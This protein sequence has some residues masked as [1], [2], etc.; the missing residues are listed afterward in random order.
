M[1]A[2][3][4][5]T[6]ETDGKLPSGQTLKEAIEIVDDVT[7]Q[8]PAYYMINCAHPTHFED[9]LS[10]GGRWTGRIRGIRAN[11][12]EKSHSQLDESTELDEGNPFELGRQ[13]RKLLGKLKNINVLG[14]CC[15]TDLRHVREIARFCAHPARLP[16]VGK[17]LVTV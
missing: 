14:G 13:Y 7:D 5:F 6:V 2:V 11:S 4:S 8:Y 17:E 15:G 10:A 16:V 12:S 9:V 1:P 3:I